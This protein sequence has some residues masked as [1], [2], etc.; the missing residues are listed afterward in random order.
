[1]VRLG[2]CYGNLMVDVR[3]SNAKLR[4]RALRI[5]VA[6]TG[7]PGDAAAELLV[8]CDGEVKTAII[9]GLCGLDPKAA[10][11]ALAASGGRVRA[12]VETS[13]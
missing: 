5:V 8:R 6:A 4:T 1:M 12:V 2:K 11:S 9:V 7:M 3:A 13:R 10:R